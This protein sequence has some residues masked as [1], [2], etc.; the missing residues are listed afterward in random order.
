VPACLAAEAFDRSTALT[1]PVRIE[2][3]EILMLLLQHGGDL[4][5]VRS[6]GKILRF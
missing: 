6:A 3:W 4:L 5:A 1:L 2:R